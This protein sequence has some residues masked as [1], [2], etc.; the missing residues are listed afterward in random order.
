MTNKGGGAL[1]VRVNDLFFHIL[2]S[3]ARVIVNYGGRT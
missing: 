3:D 1:N 2:N